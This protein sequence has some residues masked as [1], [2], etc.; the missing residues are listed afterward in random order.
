MMKGSFQI[1][2]E[3]WFMDGSEIAMTDLSKARMYRKDKDEGEDF[4]LIKHANVFETQVFAIL[5]KGIDQK[6]H[7]QEIAHM[8]V[9]VQ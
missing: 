8:C 5:N 9:I 1:T 2:H 4:P 3:V 6:G 7:G